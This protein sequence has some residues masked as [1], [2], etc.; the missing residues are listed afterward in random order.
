[1]M[2]VDDDDTPETVPISAYNEIKAECAHWKAKTQELENVLK[3][4][5]HLARLFG[6]DPTGGTPTPTVE[7]SKLLMTELAQGRE[8]SIIV[9]SFER[10]AAE[11]P[12][13]LDLNL[14]ENDNMVRL[15]PK[16]TF[17]KKLRYGLFELNKAHI[18]EFL[19]NA[20]EL[21]LVVDESPSPSGEKS[22]S[23]AG[24]FDQHG[25]FICLGLTETN[26][27]TSEG[28]VA[29]TKKILIQNECMDL[30]KA[31]IRTNGGSIMSDSASAQKKANRLLMGH[32]TGQVHKGEESISCLMHLV[33][34]AEKYAFKQLPE[35][36]QAHLNSIKLLLGSRHMSGYHKKSIKPCFNALLGK[37]RA[38][39]FHTDKGSRYGVNASNA[40]AM[41]LH[42]SLVMDTLDRTKNGGQHAAGLKTALETNWLELAMV[43][44]CFAMFYYIVLSPFHSVVSKTLPWADVKESL[45]LTREK[46][47]AL[48]EP[49]AD[50]FELFKL[51]V[52]RED[53]ISGDT[54]T[55]WEIAQNL[56]KDT[57]RKPFVKDLCARMATAV[58][59]KF[60][61]DTKRLLKADFDP[62]LVLPWTN[63][64]VES[65]FAHMKELMGRNK[66]LGDLM[67]S[68]VTQ[69][70]VNNL[71]DWIS[72]Q[73]SR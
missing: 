56:Y 47:V 38:A 63:R 51:A 18:K 62:S 26:D 17:V 29:A 61:K 8:A 11:F 71:A 39:V 58:L 24:A 10:L 49:T 20:T 1:M 67:F 50:P 15:V 68:D 48:A 53:N 64:R 31:K 42:K 13:L 33:S 36:A 30:V 40:R 59:V 21:T 54:K 57:D 23:A 35:S 14:G 34:N 22:F 66:N 12:V 43:F 73:V 27:K 44:A 7:M 37:P 52:P 45:V 3:R 60:D 4:L 19:E 9:A 55:M 70:K 25:R 65:C 69:A 5:E 28:I 16:Q 2:S 46:I 32:F 41:L 72:D 6:R